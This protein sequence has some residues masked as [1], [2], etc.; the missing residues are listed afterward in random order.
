VIELKAI[1]VLFLE[2]VRLAVER[3]M[4][5]STRF[6]RSYRDLGRWMAKQT[7]LK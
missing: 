6:L 5:G 4:G 1:L 3:L 2:L 7:Q